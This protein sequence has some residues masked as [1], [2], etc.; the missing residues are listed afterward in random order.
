MTATATLPNQVDFQ[1]HP[2][3]Y[4]HWKLEI[5]GDVATLTMAVDAEQAGRCFGVA[6]TRR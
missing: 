4:R 2:D 5:E 1:T 3:R 6:G